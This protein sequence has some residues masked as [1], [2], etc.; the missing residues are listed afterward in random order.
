MNLNSTIIPKS[1]QLNSDDLIAGP[2]TIKITNVLPGSKEQPISITYEND[3]ARPYKPS[4]SMR[5]VLV[6]IWGSEGDVY[7]GRRLTLYRDASVKFGGDQVGGIKISHASDIKDTASMMLTETRGKK[8][9]HVV[10]PLATEEGKPAVV[11]ANLPEEW[12]SLSNEERGA[13]RAKLGLPA[14]QEWWGTL[15]NTEKKTLKPLLDGQWRAAAEAV[16]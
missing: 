5:R 4:K 15:T 10:E 8:K 14:L 6:T 12:A 13:N 7:V 1:D 9:P 3:S 16:K 11:L 2:L